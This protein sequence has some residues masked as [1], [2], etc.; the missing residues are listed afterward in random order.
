MKD[1]DYLSIES[2]I[3]K[4]LLLDVNISKVESETLNRQLEWLESLRKSPKKRDMSQ[5]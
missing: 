3:R 4:K 5:A 2:A 1:I